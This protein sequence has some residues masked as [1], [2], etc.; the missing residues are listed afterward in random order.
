MS[1]WKPV[2]GAWM[3]NEHGRTR[4]VKSVS[5]MGVV[6]I[7]GVNKP[8]RPDGENTWT[9]RGPEVGRFGFVRETSTIRPATP[10]EIA[11]AEAEESKVIEHERRLVEQAK[12][13]R[14]FL[15]SVDW[16][17]FSDCAVTVMAADVRKQLERVQ[18]G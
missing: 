9:Y 18:N 3:T 15:A 4:R 13:D 14:E 8:F 17:Q 10:E 16:T 12:C 2:K 11:A 7:S 6:V 5:R 1:E